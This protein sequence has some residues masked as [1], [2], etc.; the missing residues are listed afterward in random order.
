MQ[1]LCLLAVGEAIAIAIA[2]TATATATAT[3]A[4][5]ASSPGLSLYLQDL[6]SVKEESLSKHSRQHHRPAARSTSK[7]LDRQR[8][9]S[10]HPFPCAMH[11]LQRGDDA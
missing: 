3:A 8:T 1:W 5:N 4:M 7:Q 9:A 11:I 6:L 2:V 10:A